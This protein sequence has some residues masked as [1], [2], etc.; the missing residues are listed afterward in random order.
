MTGTGTVTVSWANT[1]QGIS[2]GIGDTIQLCAGTAT[3]CDP[4]SADVLFVF[5]PEDLSTSAT[6]TVGTPV[7]TAGGAGATLTAGDY[8][9]QVASVNPTNTPP[10]PTYFLMGGL[11]PITISHSGDRPIWLQSFERT[12]GEEPC[13]RNWSP[14]WAQWPRE[15]DGGFVCNRTMYADAEDEQVPDSPRASRGAPWL[16]SVARESSE[17]TCPEGWDPSWAQWPNDGAGGPTCNRTG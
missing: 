7:S 15:R 17:A 12:S 5:Y 3:S 8:V 1:A 11:F 4:G 16:Q 2:G 13:P 10:V 14:S 6:L 9:L